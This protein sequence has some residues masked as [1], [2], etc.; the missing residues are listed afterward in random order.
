MNPSLIDDDLKDIP[1]SIAN[2]GFAPYLKFDAD[3][4]KLW[5][6]IWKKHLV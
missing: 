5:L 6:G 3:S 4:V 2:F 1:Y